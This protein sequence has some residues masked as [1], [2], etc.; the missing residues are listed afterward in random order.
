VAHVCRAN[1]SPALLTKKPALAAASAVSMGT[2]YDRAERVDVKVAGDVNGLRPGDVNR[3]RRRSCTACGGE[4]AAPEVVHRLRRGR[5][6][7]RKVKVPFSPAAGVRRHP[8]RRRVH[9][10]PVEG[11]LTSPAPKA[12]PRPPGRRPAHVHGHGSAR[13]EG[14][15]FT[16]ASLRSASFRADGGTGR[17]HDSL[18][19][20][21]PRF[22]SPGGQRDSALR[23]IPAAARRTSPG[24]PKARRAGWRDRF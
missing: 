18:L 8:R 6:I 16:T 22:G 12:R 13:A 14:A 19:R 23:P 9:V 7:I 2:R 15:A 5:A 10:R 17:R 11:R 1:A 24:R 21:W 4:P 20:A 3:L